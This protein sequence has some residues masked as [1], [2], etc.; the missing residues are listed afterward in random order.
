MNTRSDGSDHPRIGIEYDSG[1]LRAEVAREDGL[2]CEDG[3]WGHC[4]YAE[5]KGWMCRCRV[6]NGKWKMEKRE[7]NPKSRK[8]DKKS[9]RPEHNGSISARDN[10]EL[11][12]SFLITP[13]IPCI[14]FTGCISFCVHT[15]QPYAA[16]FY[17][18]TTPCSMMMI[19]LIKQHS[20]HV[21]ILPPCLHTLQSPTL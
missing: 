9:A 7:M 10:H 15:Q 2:R 19:N 13:D 11:L 21:P 4:L 8:R 12:A 6:K 18:T 1:G 16:T 17:T 20:P 14:F 5:K 3:L